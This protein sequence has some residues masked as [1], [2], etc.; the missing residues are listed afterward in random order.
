M[1]FELKH[2]HL[3]EDGYLQRGS[4]A[5]EKLKIQLQTEVNQVQTPEDIK[6]KWLQEN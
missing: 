6:V 4:R 1:T 3:L 2:N 5:S